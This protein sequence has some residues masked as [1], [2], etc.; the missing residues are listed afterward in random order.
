[1]ENYLNNLFCREFT[2]NKRLKKLHADTFAGI[3]NITY[4]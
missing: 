1:M 4:V 2:F 3:N